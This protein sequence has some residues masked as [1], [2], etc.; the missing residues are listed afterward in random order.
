ME[1][2]R[3]PVYEDNWLIRRGRAKIPVKRED[4]LRVISN[5]DTILVRASVS[6]DMATASLSRV[7]MD[8]A[9]P[10]VTGGPRVHGAEQCRYL[11]GLLIG[12]YLSKSS[13]ARPI[14]Q[15]T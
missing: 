7:N 4:F 1:Q 10:T 3:V 9:V 6:Q 13:S 12:Y 2:R 15:T 11:I 14:L 5:I 8:I